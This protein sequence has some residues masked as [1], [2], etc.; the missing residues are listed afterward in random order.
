MGSC[1]AI[2][3]QRRA[4]GGY[5]VWEGP[6]Q[7]EHDPKRQTFIGEFIDRGEALCAAHDADHG[8]SDGVIELDDEPDGK[9]R[10][11]VCEVYPSFGNIYAMDESGARFLVDWRP[12]GLPIEQFHEGRVLRGRPDERGC[13]RDVQIQPI[14]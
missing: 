5:W 2:Y 10:V 1:T 13:L 12:V 9:R 6:T 4:T 14:W 7:V 11:T 8:T 3:V